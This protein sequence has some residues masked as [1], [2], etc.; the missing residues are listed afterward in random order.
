MAKEL[1]ATPVE[2]Q[3]SP[4]QVWAVL[5]DFSSFPRWN[6]FIRKA[7]GPIT[8]GSK[9]KIELRLY[10]KT[11]M[12]LSPTLIMVEP[13]G[14]LRWFAGNK[15]SGVFDVERFFIL[16]PNASGGTLFRQGED[17]T[18]FL[19]P[20]ILS[21]GLETRILRGYERLGRALKKR[22]ERLATTGSADR[23]PPA[24]TPSYNDNRN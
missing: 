23:L 14:E 24:A 19:A 15:P 4:E 5:T 16:E 3:A 10:G 1:R 17:C 12:P 7:S 22:S 20:F 21:L 11:L 6:P 13:P 9:I 8:P 18:G 2:I